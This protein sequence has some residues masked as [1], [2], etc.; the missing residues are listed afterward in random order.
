M[1]DKPVGIT[2]HDVVAKLRKVTGERR[3]GHAGTLDPLASGLMLVAIGRNHTK[4]LA[5]YVGLDKTYTAEITFGASSETD[6]AE[7]PIHPKSSRQPERGE[8]EDVIKIMIGSQL[9]LPPQFSAKKIGGKK[10]YEL[11]RAGETAPVVPKNITIHQLRL[12]VYDYPKCSLE[13]EVSSGT[14]IRSI[15]RDLGEKLGTGAYLSGLRRTR[16]G[17]WTVAGALPLN[18]LTH[19]EQLW[20]HKIESIK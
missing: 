1:I 8:L 9:Q 13:C 6:D 15:A 5:E 19:S 17:E 16:V 10:A 3:I 11:A 12:L 2:S 4:Q 14:Y 18:D 20:D 7:G